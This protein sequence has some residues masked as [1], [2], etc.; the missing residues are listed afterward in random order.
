M[1]IFTFFSCFIPDG[2]T[3]FFDHLS[4]NFLTCMVVTA[5]PMRNIDAAAAAAAGLVW[6]HLA[7]QVGTP[8]IP[9]IQ[10]ERALA[11]RVRSYLE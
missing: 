8:G 2:V 9:A 5:A 11:P 3:P 4:M 7:R 10:L 1:G 6:G